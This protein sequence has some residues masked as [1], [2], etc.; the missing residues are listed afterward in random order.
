MQPI[1]QC[2]IFSGHASEAIPVSLAIFT[3]RSLT[4]LVELAL[5]SDLWDIIVDSTF[6]TDSVI[7]FMAACDSTDFPV[8]QSNIFETELLCDE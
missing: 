5:G 1:R 7:Q 3:A 8:T 4:Y 2:V 6:E